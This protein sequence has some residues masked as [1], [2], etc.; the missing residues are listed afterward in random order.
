M[1]E[2]DLFVALQG[3]NF[4]GAEFVAQAFAKGAS[5]AVAPSSLR[6]RGAGLSE[7]ERSR[8][9]YCPDALAA[10]GALAGA[11]RERSGVF[12][13]AVTG[14]V[15]KTT[16]KDLLKAAFEEG[17]GPTLATEGNFNNQVGVPWTLFRLGK[18][19]AAAVLELGAGD[20]GEIAALAGITR[21]DLAMITR[22]ERA[23]LEAFGDLEGVARAK[24]ELFAGLKGGAAAV[25][26]LDD[27]YIKAMGEALK[28][29]SGFEGRIFTYGSAGS[30]ADAEL[31]GVEE[32]PDGG[33]SLA[34]RG[35]P[36]GE[37]FRL[38]APVPG[39]HNAW[40]AFSAA[41]AAAAAGVPADAVRRGL[42]RATLPAGRGRLV[43][44]GGLAIIDSSYNASPGAVAAELARLSGLPGPR[45]ALLSD[46]LEMGASGPELHREAGRLA[47]ASGL[48][49]LAL[50]GDLCRDTLAGALEAGF[51]RSRARRFE[52]PLEAAEWARGMSGGRG[53]LLVKGSHATGLW[54]AVG[55]LAP[56]AAGQGG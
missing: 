24:L 43:R 56:E 54:K 5:G 39:R 31:L 42:A 6:R 27:P 16:V 12:L 52:S 14:S 51:P 44:S 33:W 26:N 10:L 2:G 55:L 4:D 41:A 34:V 49:Y 50:A 21:P 46:M 8:V 25:V 37:G 30:G 53:T 13:A 9:A 11:V 40:N 3:A 22:V 7:G 45:G 29:D 15:G 28:K 19:H 20:F 48:D 35:G 18:N 47:A 36:F 23:H 38:E 1:K 17:L 32:L